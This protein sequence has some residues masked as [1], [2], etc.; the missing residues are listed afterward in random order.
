MHATFLHHKVRVGS[1]QRGEALGVNW[2]HYHKQAGG[3]AARTRL[4]AHNT[5]TYRPAEATQHTQL[6]SI[7]SN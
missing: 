4:N 5:A 1:Y 3:Q 6:W 2:S 7:S